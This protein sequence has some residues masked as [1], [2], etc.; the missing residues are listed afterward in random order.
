MGTW[1]TAGGEWPPGPSRVRAA[2]TSAISKVRFIVL[3]VVEAGCK[4]LRNG[5]PSKL[6][7][8]S[9]MSK[10]LSAGENENA[11]PLPLLRSAIGSRFHP[12]GDALGARH[13]KFFLVPDVEVP[14]A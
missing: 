14:H 13:V 10:H 7:F 5:S 8:L 12:N 3:L 11:F 4:P 6:A 9:E 2:T 1:P